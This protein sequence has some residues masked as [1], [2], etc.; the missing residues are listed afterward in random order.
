MLRHRVTTRHQVNDSRRLKIPLT[1]VE[2]STSNVSTAHDAYA[3]EARDEREPALA[4][5]EAHVLGDRFEVND[6]RPTLDAA[7]R[8]LAFADYSETGARASY[9]R[10]L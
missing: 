1:T 5:T 9:P 8:W 10:Y 3:G 6:V 7:G 2:N 4:V